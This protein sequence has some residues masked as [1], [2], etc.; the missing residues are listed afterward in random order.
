MEQKNDY[1]SINFK[2]I[3]YIIN[4][5]KCIIEQHINTFIKYI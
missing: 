5:E 3:K 2:N 1:D 4:G